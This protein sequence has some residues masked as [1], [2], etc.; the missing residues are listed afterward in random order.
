MTPKRVQRR[1]TKGWRKPPN[2]VY[3][4]R[5]S[6]W[7]N[8]FRTDQFRTHEQ[9]CE[10]QETADK[11]IPILLQIPA[12]VRFVSLE[13]LLSSMA[14]S[15][16]NI[17]ALTKL[18]ALDGW[19]RDI[20]PKLGQLSS[21]KNIHH[22]NWVIVGCESLGGRAGRFQ[23]GFIKAAISIVRQCKEAGVPAFVKQIPIDGKVVKD[24]TKFPEELQVRQYPKGGE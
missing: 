6:K 24:I 16:V 10:N 20:S 21:R 22:L 14:L 7:G 15:R 5:S 1:R 12:A 9:T 18:N 13:P 4:G 17:D 2:T 23:D 11:R 3:I 19:E 8:P